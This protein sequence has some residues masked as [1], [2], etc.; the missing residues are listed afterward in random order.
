M[1]IETYEI[2]MAELALVFLDVAGRDEKLE[3]A[4]KILS[5]AGGLE[6]S[7]RLFG[8][9]L[10]H[11]ETLQVLA[12]LSDVIESGDVVSLVYELHGKIHTI[13]TVPSKSI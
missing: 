12:N 1:S 7:Q 6:V 3:Q 8:F 9:R 2:R 13:L 4:R 10:K 11:D 5:Q